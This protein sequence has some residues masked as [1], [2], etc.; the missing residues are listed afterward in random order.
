ME[1]LIGFILP[2]IIDLVNSKVPNTKLRFWI[3][4]VICAVIGVAIKYKELAVGNVDVALGSVSLVFAEAQVIYYQFWQGSGVR[5]SLQK[6][7]Q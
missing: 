6:R 7:L 4:F 1:N 5:E 2:P 3:A